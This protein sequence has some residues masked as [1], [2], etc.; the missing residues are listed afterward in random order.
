MN[1]NFRKR[2]TTIGRKTAAAGLTILLAAPLAGAAD[3]DDN[4]DGKDFGRLVERML[5]QNSEKYFGFDKPLEESAPA[6]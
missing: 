3:K 4:F 6:T 5:Q 2:A 1:N